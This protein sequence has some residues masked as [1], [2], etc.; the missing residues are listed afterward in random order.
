[1][2]FRISPPWASLLW[3][4][5]GA[6]APNITDACF[7]DNATESF[8]TDQSREPFSGDF[9][10]QTADALSHVLASGVGM[11]IP[12][13]AYSATSRRVEMKSGLSRRGRSVS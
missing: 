3:R 9:Q 11:I 12:G 6:T 10:P 13:L 1:M 2:S 8:P 4:M 5:N 7:T